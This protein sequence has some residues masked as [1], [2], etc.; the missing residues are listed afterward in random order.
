MKNLLLGL[1]AIILIASGAFLLYYNWQDNSEIGDPAQINVPA[2]GQPD[3]GASEEEE[4]IP[5]NSDNMDQADE[6]DFDEPG[7]W[8]DQENIVADENALHVSGE[9]NVFE[10]TVLFALY[11]E[12]NVLIETSSDFAQSPDVG[13]I[14]GFSKTLYFAA[15]PA[16][17][18]HGYLEVYS[19]SPQDGSQM[20]KVTVPV[21]FAYNDTT[22]LTVYF[23]HSAPAGSPGECT[24][25][26][27]VSRETIGTL[28]VAK[29]TLQAMLLGPNAAEEAEGFFSGIPSGTTLN[30]VYIQ[31]G[32]AYADFSSELNSTAGSC[33]VA[34]VTAMIRENL[35]QF[36]TINDVVISVEGQT[37]DILQP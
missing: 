36:D 35:L 26:Q 24:Y 33:G 19:E 4:V 14:G 15:P 20:Y 2:I 1:A 18:V 37:E 12:D 21:Y 30:S 16:N 32:V 22:E 6:F 34:G 28:A 5:G 23:S 7:I 3:N 27:T 9:A 8:V 25:L 29:A 17:I 11:G 10:N 13:Q 31:D